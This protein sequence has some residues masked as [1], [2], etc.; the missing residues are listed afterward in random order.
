MKDIVFSFSKVEYFHE[1]PRLHIFYMAPKIALGLRY[2]DFIG[3]SS[4]ISLS[5]CCCMLNGGL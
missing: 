2:L 3:K 1:M 5:E 4:I